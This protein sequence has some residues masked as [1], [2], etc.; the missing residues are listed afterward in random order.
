M[1][2]NSYIFALAASN[3]RLYAGFD[4]GEIGVFDIT[5]GLSLNTLQSSHTSCCLSSLTIMGENLIA[6]YKDR[7]I[8]ILNIK[9]IE[10][11]NIEY[12]KT[13]LKDNNLSDFS[14]SLI[15]PD[16]KYV[17]GNYCLASLDTLSS[18]I[19]I[20]DL[21]SQ[22]SIAALHVHHCA[23]IVSLA[24]A[25]EMLY[26]GLSNGEIKIIDLKSLQHVATLAINISEEDTAFFPSNLA[27]IDGN[28]YVDYITLS[29]CIVQFDFTST[30]D[31]V[32]KEI[33]E[34]L[35]NPCS[36]KVIQNA[37]ERFSR[38]PRSAKNRVYEELY[39]LLK[40]ENHYWGWGEHAFHDQYPLSCTPEK[41]GLAILNYLASL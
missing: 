27:I 30:H 22:E 25:N 40:P 4:H 18:Y 5:T 10:T 1:S 14:S 28:L 17:S 11:P 23:S 33:A 32:F 21:M 38:M 8:E 15:T 12:Q 19:E 20:K 39:L 6:V 29:D 9:E 41:K 24:C 35:M 34:H 16:G 26:V 7:S 3:R 31:L 37:I 13:V 36:A 2:N